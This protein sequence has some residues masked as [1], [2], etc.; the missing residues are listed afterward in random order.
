M[1]GRN[2]DLR[3]GDPFWGG[4]TYCTY[5]GRRSAGLAWAEH[6]PFIEIRGEEG[7]VAGPIAW[8]QGMFWT[9]DARVIR[10]GRPK[11]NPLR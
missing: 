6:G 11:K 9:I 5:I 2:I 3:C 10:Q 8:L 1:P 7:S 4:C